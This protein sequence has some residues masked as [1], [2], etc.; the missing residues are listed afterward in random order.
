[1]VMS[2]SHVGN[3]ISLQGDDISPDAGTF[4]FTITECIGREQHNLQTLLADFDD[5]FG[6]PNGLPPQRQHTHK[7][8]LTQ[9]TDLVV[10]WPYRYP[11][12]QKDEIERQ[13]DEMLRQRIIR[14]S[15]SPFS[16]PVLLV[17]KTY[18]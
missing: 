17:S 12:A 5:I 16:S 9:G 4:A 1:M 2:F 13:C 15:T 8:I 3:L 18:K 6:E 10:V 7:I 14:Q 11:H